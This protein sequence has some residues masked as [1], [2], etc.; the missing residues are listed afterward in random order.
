MKKQGKI[1]PILTESYLA[2]WEIQP[3]ISNWQLLHP[4]KS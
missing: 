4:Q 2:A 1:A 3:S